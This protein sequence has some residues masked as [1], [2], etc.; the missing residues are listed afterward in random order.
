M[1]AACCELRKLRWGDGGSEQDALA[2]RATRGVMA[3]AITGK[4]KTVIRFSGVDMVMTITRKRK[5]L[6]NFVGVLMPVVSVT[7]DT[8]MMQTVV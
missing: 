8:G 4:S 6:S 3:V 5:P 2:E 7:V 1:V